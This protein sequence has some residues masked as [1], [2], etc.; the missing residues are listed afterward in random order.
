MSSEADVNKVHPDVMVGWAAV[1]AATAAGRGSQ[2]MSETVKPLFPAAAGGGVPPAR[3]KFFSTVAVRLEQE[4]SPISVKILALLNRLNFK[5][6]N[7]SDLFHRFQFDKVA[8]AMPLRFLSPLAQALA[9]AQIRA[10]RT[11]R[12]IGDRLAKMDVANGGEA[13]R[14]AKMDVAKGGETDVIR[15]EIEGVPVGLARKWMIDVKSAFEKLEFTHS[16]LNGKLAQLSD[17]VSASIPNNKSSETH[18]PS[19]EVNP[20]STDTQSVKSA[21]TTSSVDSTSARNNLESVANTQHN[22]ISLPVSKMYSGIKTEYPS[23][24]NH[25]SQSVRKPSLAKSVEQFERLKASTLSSNDK[26]LNNV[27]NPR[28]S[29]VS[30]PKF[31]IPK[32]RIQPGTQTV[33]PVYPLSTGTGKTDDN[34]A[35]FSVLNSQSPQLSNKSTREKNPKFLV[36]GRQ[37]ID[38]NPKFS[39]LHV[40]QSTH[41]NQE[42]LNPPNKY[43]HPSRLRQ[44]DNVNSS[45]SPTTLAAPHSTHLPFSQRVTP[46]PTGIHHTSPNPFLNLSTSL[47]SSKTASQKASAISHTRQ[48]PGSNQTYNN[49]KH[50]S[51]SQSPKNPIVTRQTARELPEINQI[52]GADRIYTDAQHLIQANSRL[53]SGEYALFLS[54]RQWLKQFRSICDR[55]KESVI[56]GN[57][58]SPVVDLLGDLRPKILEQYDSTL[59]IMYVTGKT[60]WHSFGTLFQTGLV[61]PKDTQ[62]ISR[63]CRKLTRDLPWL[64]QRAACILLSDLGHLDSRACEDSARASLQSVRSSIANYASGTN[65]AF[66]T[67]VLKD[68]GWNIQNLRYL[69]AFHGQLLAQ[70]VRGIHVPELIQKDIALVQQQLQK[71]NNMQ[72]SRLKHVSM[73]DLSLLPRITGS[74]IALR[75]KSLNSWLG[76]M[77]E[78]FQNESLPCRSTLLLHMAHSVGP[79][80][81]KMEHSARINAMNIFDLACDILVSDGVTKSVRSLKALADRIGCPN[82]NVNRY[83]GTVDDVTIVTD[84]TDHHSHPIYKGGLELLERAAKHELSFEYVNNWIRQLDDSLLPHMSTT[85]TQLHDLRP[86]ILHA[87]TSIPG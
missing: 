46:G 60:V 20:G 9:A 54:L 74:L 45:A 76:L 52:P 25:S 56:Y 65:R 5:D 47:D 31:Q 78:V 6:Q 53:G 1:Y 22:H 18:T 36:S 82:V 19:T 2:G 10:V 83:L 30:Q 71:R 86:K 59:K 69:S 14:V 41:I 61:T 64:S 80:I 26:I 50:G 12:V 24:H 75:S 63:A 55:S 17:G 58:S 8:E 44:S 43:L 49:A 42:S 57:G 77:F 34:K 29:D 3:A 85:V 62:F 33:K 79:V 81:S 87:V 21:Q 7:F 72:G 23:D 84:K 27:R 38:Q 37:V 15:A 40:R 13:G 28:L 66:P 4:S 73:S 11:M 39:G 51:H 35:T 32:K 67:T 16:E 68:R 48:I 70:R